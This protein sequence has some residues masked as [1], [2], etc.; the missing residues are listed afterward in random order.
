MCPTIFDR[1]MRL[2]K[3]VLEYKFRSVKRVITMQA[4]ARLMVSCGC[5]VL[6]VKI[7]HI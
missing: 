2:E 7:L 5:V 1:E 3:P 6:K 4:T